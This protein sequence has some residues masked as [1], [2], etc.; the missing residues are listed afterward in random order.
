MGKREAE[1]EADALDM[2]KTADEIAQLQVRLQDQLDRVARND[3]VAIR[4]Q[5][6]AARSHE[7]AQRKQAEADLQQ[8]RALVAR[9]CFVAGIRS[10]DDNDAVTWL[11]LADRA[12]HDD[13]EQLAEVE[14]LLTP[15]PEP[16]P[17][18]TTRPQQRQPRNPARQRRRRKRTNVVSFP[19]GR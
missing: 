9:G 18:P 3:R 8:R 14:E 11:E 4:G 19:G 12:L 17:T 10:A 13:L 7:L 16:I 15:D 2:K 6:A 5:K 1:L